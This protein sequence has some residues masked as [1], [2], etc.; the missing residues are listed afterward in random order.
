MEPRSAALAE[1]NTEER[2]ALE[3]RLLQ[4]QSGKCFICDKDMDLVLHAG[5]LDVDHIDLW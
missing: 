3:N 4:R 2:R 1:L 5:K